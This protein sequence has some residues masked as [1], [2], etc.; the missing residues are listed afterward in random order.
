MVALEPGLNSPFCFLWVPIQTETRPKWVFSCLCPCQ[1]EA[2]SFLLVPSSKVPGSQ[3][4][5]AP[6]L[7]SL[8]IAR[9]CWVSSLFPLRSSR[10]PPAFSKLPALEASF[11]KWCKKEAGSKQGD[12]FITLKWA[13]VMPSPGRGRTLRMMDQGCHFWTRFFRWRF[14]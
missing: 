10:L 9:P 8:K 12:S 11:G 7:K 13:P 5:E 4:F 1:H 6:I 14:P 3:S 2:D